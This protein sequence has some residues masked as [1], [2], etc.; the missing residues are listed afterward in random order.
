MPAIISD[1]HKFVFI[2]V[3]KTAGTSIAN[4]ILSNSKRKK[5]FTIKHL[6]KEEHDYFKFA[7]I[8]NPWD[9]LVSLYF[10]SNSTYSLKKPK[11]LIFYKFDSC[12]EFLEGFDKS[13]LMNI[14]KQLFLQYWWLQDKNGDVKLDYIGR[15]ENLQNDFDYVCNKIGIS[16]IKLQHLNKSNHKHYSYYYNDKT[17]DKI[18]KIYKKDIELGNYKFEKEK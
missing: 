13:K 12:E 14:T 15:F 10:Y 17:I 6:N 4:N 11:K 9:W 1:K 18:A 2:H 3:P 8:R 5:G 16:S 7:F